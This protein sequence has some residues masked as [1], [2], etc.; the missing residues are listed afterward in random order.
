M[1]LNAARAY[2]A[3][4]DPKVTALKEATER[5]TFWQWDPR[6]NHAFMILRPLVGVTATNEWTP[7]AI[8]YVRWSTEDGK[9]E[10]LV[11][12]DAHSTAHPGTY[13][14]PSKALKGVERYVGKALAGTL[15]QD[16]YGD[17]LNAVSEVLEEK[18]GKDV[19]REVI[20]AVVMREIQR[21]NG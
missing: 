8:C 2:R 4:Q 15:G 19:K 1:G 12:V 14:D 10:T 5:A 13:D 18:F 7:G 16:A 21:K 11:N 9:Y 3:S 6:A 17:L 20:A